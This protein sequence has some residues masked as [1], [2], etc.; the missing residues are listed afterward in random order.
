MGLLDFIKSKPSE[1]SIKK[2]LE[3]SGFEISDCDLD[4][5]SCSSKFPSSLKFEDDDGGSL[6]NTTKPF[7]LQVIVPTGKNDWVHDPCLESNTLPHAVNKWAEKSEKKFPQLGENTNVK[8]AVSSQ[9]TPSLDDGAQETSE[10]L[11]L[12]LFVWVKGVT[13]ENVGKVLDMTIPKILEYRSQGLLELPIKKIDEIAFPEVEIVSCICS[14][15]VF[16]CSHKTRDKRCG[17]TAPIMKKE[18]EIH[19]RD[20]NLIR[21]HGDYRPGGVTVAYVNHVGGHKYAANVII[22]LKNS[23]KNIFLARIRPNNVKPIIDEC[24]LAN[25]KVWPSKVRMVQKFNA[26]EW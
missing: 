9:T 11:L 22:Y 3:D 18:L 13:K 16:L 21:D 1:A 14:S 12:P 7:G 24:I 15:Y 26:I 4:C 25:G 8:V 2:S 10:I 5:G 17:I 20:L 23:G 19:L 6:Y